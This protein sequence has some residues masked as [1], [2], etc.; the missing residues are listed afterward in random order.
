M[1][2]PRLRGRQHR[3][4]DQATTR[5]SVV[6]PFPNI[7]GFQGARENHQG[8][9]AQ[10]SR[11]ELDRV[12]FGSQL[13]TKVPQR[14]G[15]QQRRLPFTPITASHGHRPHRTQPPHWPR[16]CCHLPHPPVRLR[17]ERAAYTGYRLGWARVPPFKTHSIYLASSLHRRRL[18]R[19]LPTEITHGAPRHPQQLRR[20][21]FDQRLHR[22]AARQPRDCRREHRRSSWL[23]FQATRRLPAVHHGRRETTAFWSDLFTDPPSRRRRRGNPPTYGRL[24][25]RTPPEPNRIQKTYIHP[26][27]THAP[28]RG[29]TKASSDDKTSSCR[30]HAAHVT[31]TNRIKAGPSFDDFSDV[32]MKTDASDPGSCCRPQQRPPP[33]CP[34]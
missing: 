1:D 11:P 4:G 9:G 8:W 33:P 3:L 15:K 10:C 18:W 26:S 24:W 27:T 2:T 12:P 13:H 19:L 14:Y 20:A 32:A 22:Q 16:N 7:F 21:Y 17:T 23:G 34:R 29:P 5:A 31:P 30:P 28:G 25:V 6:H